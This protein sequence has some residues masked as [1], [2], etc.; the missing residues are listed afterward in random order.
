VPWTAVEPAA[1]PGETVHLAL[2][3]GNFGTTDFFAKAFE[4]LGRA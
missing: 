4:Q 1:C 2:K 3:S